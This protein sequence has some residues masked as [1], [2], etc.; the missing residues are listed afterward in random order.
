MP[1]QPPES[2]QQAEAGEQ[3]WPW[4]RGRGGP[5]S[6]PRLGPVHGLTACLPNAWYLARAGKRCRAAVGAKRLFRA[7]VRVGA[8]ARSLSRNL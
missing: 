3:P 7:A 4:L 8:A 2:P 5:S 6:S 1:P